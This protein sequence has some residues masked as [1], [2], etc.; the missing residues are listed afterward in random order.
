M[1]S[2]DIATRGVRSEFVAVVA[3]AHAAHIGAHTIPPAKLHLC[4]ARLGHRLLVEG[5]GSGFGV[6]GHPV[7]GV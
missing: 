6:L 4:E 1:L 3:N 5:L 2:R 7:A